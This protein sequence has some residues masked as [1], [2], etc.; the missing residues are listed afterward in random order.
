LELAT[1]ADVDTVSETSATVAVA[2]RLDVEGAA[3]AADP[4]QT[5]W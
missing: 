2:R 5:V 1:V 4:P 3:L